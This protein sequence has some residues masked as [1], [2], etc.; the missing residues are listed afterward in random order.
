MKSFYDFNR[1][2]PQER[3]ERNNLYPKLAQFHIALRE[4]L[5]D[6]EYQ[7]F[8]LAEKEALARYNPMYNQTSGKWAATC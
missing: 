5:S 7:A 1:N 2:S 8:Y 3:R 4:E 6:E